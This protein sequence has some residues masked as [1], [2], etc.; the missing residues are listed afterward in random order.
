MGSRE[1]ALAPTG[2]SLWGT[3]FSGWPCSQPLPHGPSWALV[4]R[5][6]RALAGRPPARHG[7]LGCLGHW[8]TVLY[9]PSWFLDCIEN[10]RAAGVGPF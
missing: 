3:G 6:A 10:R 7:L 8:S 9:E 1:N 4:G 2:T 5:A